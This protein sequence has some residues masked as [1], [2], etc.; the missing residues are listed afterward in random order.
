MSERSLKSVEEL[1][2]LRGL[3]IVLMIVNHSGYRFADL[4]AA[5]RDPLAAVVFLGSFAPVIFFFTTGFGVALARSGPL[6]WSSFAS[7]LGK[8]ALLLL[9]DHFMF[10]R[11]GSTGILDFLGF[12]ALSTVLV[13]AVSAS[14]RSHTWSI[15]LI[16]AILCLRF[17]VGP[18]ARH[19]LDGNSIVLAW[20]L[21][22]TS[23]PGVSYPL[24]PWMVYPLLGFLAGRSYVA[25]AALRNQ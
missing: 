1:D 23:V 19:H 4:Q 10:W 7:V 21:G 17:A 14:K 13:P 2:L 22:A 6:E 12:I 9:A 20:L 3:A 15:S 8:A 18:L 24:S 16:I 5:S 11:E 25:H